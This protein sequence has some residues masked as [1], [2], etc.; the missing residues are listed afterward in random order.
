M[1][2]SCKVMGNSIISSVEDAVTVLMTG[3]LDVLV[4]ESHIFAKTEQQSA[5][6]GGRLNAAA[7]E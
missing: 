7:A 2:M 5:A 3:G 1:T 4:I 6:L